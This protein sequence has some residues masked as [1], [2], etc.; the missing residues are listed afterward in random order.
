MNSLE[1][2]LN[3]GSVGIFGRL[4]RFWFTPRSGRNA[5]VISGLGYVLWCYIKYADLIYKLEMMGS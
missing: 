2:P 4:F 3:M 1:F 5:E